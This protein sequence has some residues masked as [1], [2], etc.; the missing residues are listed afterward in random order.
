[1][2][3]VSPSEVTVC[4]PLWGDY[5]RRWG[6]PKWLPQM[7]ALDPQPHEF[8][9]ISDKPVDGLGD[10]FRVVVEPEISQK[11]W[12]SFCAKHVR[13]RLMMGCGM[14][15]GM[16][17]DALRDLVFGGDITFGPLL[18]SDGNLYTPTRQGW[19]NIFDEPWFPLT[20]WWLCPPS[21]FER[22]KM[23]DADAWDDWIFFLE[24]KAAGIE[25]TFDTKVRNLYTHHP[26]QYSRNRPRNSMEQINLMKTLARKGGIIPG[27]CWPPQIRE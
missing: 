23:R 25:P 8:L 6:K 27:T 9:I 5:W 1:M 14:D 7:L 19:D 17:V 10:G 13:T 20:G 15:D 12:L 3:S 2:K 4:S 22:I 24:C 11:T 21:L 26:E 18:G 16:P